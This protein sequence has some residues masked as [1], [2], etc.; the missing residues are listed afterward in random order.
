MLY[1]NLVVYLFY[2]ITQYLQI[3]YKWGVVDFMNKKEMKRTNL[4][5]HY[6][7]DD[8]RRVTDD[9]L[10]TF[11]NYDWQLDDWWSVL[12]EHNDEVNV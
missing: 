11:D 1:N 3:I 7:T 8:S 5:E 2:I 4:S 10:M 9:W 12:P 6:T